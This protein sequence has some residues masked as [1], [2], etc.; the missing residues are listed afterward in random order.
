MLDIIISILEFIVIHLCHI[1]LKSKKMGSWL[2]W[3][4]LRRRGT[5]FNIYSSI[6]LPTFFSVTLQ[7]LVLYTT[8][9]LA[10]L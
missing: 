5:K 8:I 6:V 9:A 1:Y 4:T 7:Q 10:V 3:K 2:M